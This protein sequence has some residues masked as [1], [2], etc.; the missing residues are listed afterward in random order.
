MPEKGGLSPSVRRVQCFVGIFMLAVVLVTQASTLTGGK[1]P[2]GA[3]WNE[4]TLTALGISFIVGGPREQ[5]G[6]FM[7]AVSWL[8]IA[9]ALVS[10]IV[11]LRVFLRR[12]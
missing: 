10:S 4:I 5:R 11:A 3:P 7:R 2:S 1:W 8:V 12:L 6:P 9:I